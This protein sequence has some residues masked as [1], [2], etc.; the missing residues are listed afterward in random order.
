L[1]RRIKNKMDFADQLLA[2]RR[3]LLNL[4]SGNFE[5]READI[6][7]LMDDP[8]RSY[9]ELETFHINEVTGNLSPTITVRET[10]SNGWDIS[11]MKI[12]ASYRGETIPYWITESGCNGV[13]GIRIDKAYRI[14]EQTS[15][16][17]KARQVQDYSELGNL[18]QA[19]I[20]DTRKLLASVQENKK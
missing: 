11:G 12:E 8:S 4:S 2:R 5:S 6:R 7:A 20:E 3:A 14:I 1:E 19:L 9:G 15:K 16:T 10:D 18:T 13:I 17:L